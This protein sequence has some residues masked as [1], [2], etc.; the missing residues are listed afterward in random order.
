MGLEPT[1][2]HVLDALTSELLRT[3]W[4]ARAIFV[5]WTCE[6]HLA[7]THISLFPLINKIIL[8]QSCY[9]KQTASVDPSS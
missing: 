3:R 7:V 4:R 1:T 5:G 8:Y 2:L 9:L 6:P